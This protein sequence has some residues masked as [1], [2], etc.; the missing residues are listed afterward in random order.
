MSRKSR[1]EKEIGKGGRV[2][3]AQRVEGLVVVMDRQWQPQPQP[4]LWLS[5][6]DALLG[7]LLDAQ[8]QKTLRHNCGEV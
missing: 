8:L 3:Y 5:N 2:A 1:Q 7:R 4:C 6:H